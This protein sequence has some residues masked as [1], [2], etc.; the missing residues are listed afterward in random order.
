MDS[1]I[2]FVKYFG[3]RLWVFFRCL[4]ELGKWEGFG[5]ILY[6]YDFYI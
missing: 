2:K 1:V 3:K 4:G 6:L 5:L